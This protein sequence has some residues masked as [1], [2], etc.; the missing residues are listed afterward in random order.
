M[1]GLSRFEQQFGKPR[2]GWTK[3]Q[4][5][6]VAETLAGVELTPK[7]EP[8]HPVYAPGLLRAKQTNYAALASEVL[9]RIQEAKARGAK[10]TMKRAVR[11]IMT[12]SV[13]AGRDQVQLKQDYGEWYRPG[14]RAFTE[15]GNGHFETTYDAVRQIIRAW[16]SAGVV[17]RKQRKSGS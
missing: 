16:K 15:S 9:E 13:A 7:A 3:A 12:E 4:W 8:G 5:Q 1:D 14:A 10:M 2:S 6:K 17:P 11:E